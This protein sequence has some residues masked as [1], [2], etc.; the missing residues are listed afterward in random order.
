MT[1]EVPKSGKKKNPNPSERKTF[2]GANLCENILDCGR[3]NDSG[4]INVKSARFLGWIKHFSVTPVY[5]R[6]IDWFACFSVC[7]L[8]SDENSDSS[9]VLLFLLL[10]FHLAAASPCWTPEQVI[11]TFYYFFSDDLR[12]AAELLFLFLWAADPPWSIFVLIYCVCNRW[13][14]FHTCL[15]DTCGINTDT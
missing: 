6:L 15:V 13:Q 9:N 11:N 4:K 14:C 1:D 7:V 10:S 12:S 8:K 2:N 3:L 5:F